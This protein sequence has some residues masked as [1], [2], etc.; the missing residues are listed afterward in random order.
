[1]S[2]F[3]RYYA[4]LL[5]SGSHTE[6]HADEAMRDYQAMILRIQAAAIF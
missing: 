4:A 2:E 6:P 5:R 3:K 1:M